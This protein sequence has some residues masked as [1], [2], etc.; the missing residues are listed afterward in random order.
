MPVGDGA[1]AWGFFSQWGSPLPQEQYMNLYFDA[2]ARWSS[3]LSMTGLF[4][5]YN[6]N[7]NDDWESISP[8]TMWWV[9]GT[10]NSAFSNPDYLLSW[11]NRIVKAPPKGAATAGQP[12]QL[13]AGRKV[14]TALVQRGATGEEVAETGW[15]RRDELAALRVVDPL[16]AKMR[17][18]LFS[19]M[20]RQGVI[21]RRP[22]QPRPTQGLAAAELD[23]LPYAGENPSLQRVEQQMLFRKEWRELAPKQRTAMLAGS[24][25]SDGNAVGMDKMCQ[26]CI[27]GS[28]KCATLGI[29][30]DPAVGIIYESERA[31][32]VCHESCCPWV[33]ITTTRAICKCWIDCAAGTPA[34]NLVSEATLNYVAARA[35]SMVVDAGEGSCI[36]MASP[37]ASRYL[38]KEY[39]PSQWAGT[40]DN[41]AVTLWYKPKK[42]TFAIPGTK[43]ILFKGPADTE[44]VPEASISLSTLE[45]GLVLYVCALVLAAFII[46]VASFEALARCRC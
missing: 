40:F 35:L 29:T 38:A 15:S 41:F 46:L 27:K 9:K 14:G 30:A 20:A 10:M 8:S 7:S 11:D 19:K 22:G 18:R 26:Q 3:G 21:E 28:D 6:G 39:R 13:A 2:P 32:A 16:T 37:V 17:K 4:A 25:V 31:E 24:V 36:L 42:D 33:D 5:N 34:S 12:A 23:I 45:L 1:K 44:T 43:S